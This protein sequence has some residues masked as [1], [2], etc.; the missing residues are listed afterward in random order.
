MELILSPLNPNTRRTYEDEYREGGL[1]DQQRGS[2]QTRLFAR[3]FHGHFTIPYSGNFTVLDMG[4]ALGDA[5]PVWKQSYPQ[6]R[7]YGC[8]VA[9][10]A[11]RRANGQFGQL[12]H[13]FVGGFE[14]LDTPY[15]IIYC[16]NVL[17]H[18]EQYQLIAAHLIKY[19]KILYILTPFN[20]LRQRS[21]MRL[22]EGAFHVAS[23]YQDSFD[24]LSEKGLASSVSTKVFRCPGAWSWTFKYRFYRLGMSAF[25]GWPIEQ[26]PLQIGYEIISAVR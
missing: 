19:C 8:D 20:E 21:P 13:F 1:Y 9:P 15:D 4:C 3:Y 16:S 6:A 24:F 14:E 25:F 2:H 22:R 10:S 26:E 12:A 5:L 11:I 23:F 18:F 7:L 17:E